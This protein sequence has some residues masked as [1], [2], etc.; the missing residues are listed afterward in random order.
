MKSRLMRFQTGLWQ[1]TPAR[2]LEAILSQL[3][4][5]GETV[6]LEKLGKYIS[7]PDASISLFMKNHPA[8]QEAKQIIAK[9][10]QE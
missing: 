3:D 4:I 1:V 10:L 9:A 7:L 8:F 2:H 5:L 6:L